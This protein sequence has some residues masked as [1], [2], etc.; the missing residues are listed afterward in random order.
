MDSIEITL[1]TEEH[2]SVIIP[3]Y[4]GEEETFSG[5]DCVFNDEV[6]T[7]S[8]SSGYGFPTKLFVNEDCFETEIYI[9]VVNR[10]DPFLEKI[11]SR[12]EHNAFESLEVERS[13]T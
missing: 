1:I 4:L 6:Y 11:K 2:G 3:L 5:G 12:I 7:F 10:C 8:I 13:G 9:C